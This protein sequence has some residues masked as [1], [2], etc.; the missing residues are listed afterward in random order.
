MNIA[1]F[2]PFLRGLTGSPGRPQQPMW[3][4]HD[5]IDDTLML[6]LVE[7]LRQHFDETVTRL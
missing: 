7:S 1:V 6:V 3:P 4:I 2:M 5:N